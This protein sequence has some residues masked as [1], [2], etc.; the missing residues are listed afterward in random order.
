MS[1]LIVQARGLE[2]HYPIKG[3]VLRRTVGQVRAVDGVDLE[4]RAGETLGVVGESGCGKSTL[5]RLLMCL[6]P[7]TG[8][9]L[10]ILGEDAL[11]QR[12]GAGL[13]RLRRN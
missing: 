8:G 10:M 4:L 9:S 5:G 13:R 1:E 11:A 7:P 3:G 6:E 2:K 12:G